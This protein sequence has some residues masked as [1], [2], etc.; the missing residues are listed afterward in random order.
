MRNW[1]H[2]LPK[3]PSQWVFNKLERQEDGSFPDAALVGLLKDATDTV[4]GSFGARNV[5]AALKAIEIL[6][7]NQGREWGMASFNEFRSFFKLK[8]FTS[9]TEINSQPG[10]AETR[11]NRVHPITSGPG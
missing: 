3:D 2:A 10:I 6:G 11:K 9:F 5:P 7:I 4:A 8:P 1:A